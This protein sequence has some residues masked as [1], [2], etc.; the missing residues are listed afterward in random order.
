MSTAIYTTIRDT[1]DAVGKY[2]ALRPEL[3]RQVIAIREQPGGPWKIQ[4]KRAS[5][6]ADHSLPPKVTHHAITAGKVD[7]QTPEPLVIDVNAGHMQQVDRYAPMESFAVLDALGNPPE[8][9]TQAKCIQFRIEFLLRELLAAVKA[10]VGGLIQLEQVA[11]AFSIDATALSRLNLELPVF[12]Y[13]PR[14]SGVTQQDFDRLI[15]DE[16]VLLDAAKLAMHRLE[17]EVRSWLGGRAPWPEGEVLWA[18]PWG[19]PGPAYC[20]RKPDGTM[21]PLPLHDQK[22]LEAVGFEKVQMIP[23]SIGKP[24]EIPTA[25]GRVLVVPAVEH[26]FIGDPVPIVLD[27]EAKTGAALKDGQNPLEFMRI[28]DDFMKTRDPDSGVSF[29][30]FAVRRHPSKVEK[31]SEQQS[32]LNR[33]D[34]ADRVRRLARSFDELEKGCSTVFRATET[35]GVELPD[36]PGFRNLAAEAGRLLN[37]LPEHWRFGIQAVTMNDP[38]SASRWVGAM[39]DFCM[40]GMIDVPNWDETRQSECLADGASTSVL[41][42]DVLLRSSTRPHRGKGNYAAALEQARADADDILAKARLDPH[43]QFATLRLYT[44][45]V[46]NAAVII[47]RMSRLP[48]F[49]TSGQFVG[50][51]TRLEECLGRLDKIL[52][53]PNLLDTWP[54]SPGTTFSWKAGDSALSVAVAFARGVAAATWY[55]RNQAVG[56]LGHEPPELRVADPDPDQKVTAWRDATVQ[57]LR[58]RTLPA[59]PAWPMWEIVR[60]AGKLASLLRDE[61]RRAVAA[62]YAPAQP[63]GAPPP[64]ADDHRRFCIS[65]SFPGEH[66]EYVKGIDAELHKHFDAETIFYDDRF[67][68]E[69]ARPDLDIYLQN[70]YHTD[71]ELLV[72]FLCAEYER[73]QWCRLEWRAIRD[74]IKTRPPDRI[75]FFRFDD[76]P[77]QGSFSTDGYIDARKHSAN[78]AAILIR[79]R[80][81]RNRHHQQ[82]AG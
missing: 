58:E 68:S 11:I 37:E 23:A 22:R 4:Y 28:Y 33:N 53:I 18:Q 78:E 31:W 44:F 39:F 54:T 40:L 73:K 72:V 43:P 60:D 62:A 55:G 66:R 27:I 8:P 13:W 77:V 74:I 24:V 26:H 6:K 69:L 79:Q 10:I 30:E 21:M 65:F 56:V 3:L 46:F 41:A 14:I 82:R 61:Y 2:A 57:E 47:A 50:V 17:I 52:K 35:G 80:L 15:A 70:I 7:L 29:V 67:K 42:C 76:A 51:Q 34:N 1:G 45:A 49:L 63:R 5:D 59:L 71:T 38:E 20:E 64:P 9:E 48:T 16:K 19:E 25:D 75:M 36:N 12:P 81:A 32:R